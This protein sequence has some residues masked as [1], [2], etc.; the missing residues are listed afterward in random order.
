MEMTLLGTLIGQGT[1][2]IGHKR[3]ERIPYCISVSQTSNCKSGA[4]RIEMTSMHDTMDV[5]RLG[6]LTL[7]LRTG[8]RVDLIGLKPI[9]PSTVIEV[10]TIGPIPGY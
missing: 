4:G 6:A 3:F 10:R 5:F 7:E 9:E 8:E 2:I 1:A